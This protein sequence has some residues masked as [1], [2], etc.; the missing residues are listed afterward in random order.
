VNYVI[1]RSTDI[2][3]ASLR[4]LLERWKSLIRSPSSNDEAVEAQDSSVKEADARRMALMVAEPIY[5]TANNRLFSNQHLP[6]NLP[7]V[8]PGFPQD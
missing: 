3:T 4:S 7:H 2:N 1:S 5:T 6:P 8:S